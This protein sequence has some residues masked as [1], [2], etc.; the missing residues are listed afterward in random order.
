MT[1]WL[2]NVGSL[3]I[4]R[5]DHGLNLRNPMSKDNHYRDVSLNLIQGQETVPSS[6]STSWIQERSQAIFH[7]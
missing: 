6:L 7:D 1:V 3:H 5:F 4:F 2:H